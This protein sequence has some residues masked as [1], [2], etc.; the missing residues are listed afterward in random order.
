LTALL[1]GATALLLAPATGSAQ[2]SMGAPYYAGRPSYYGSG[3]APYSPGALSW[4]GAFSYT[5]RYYWY[6]YNWPYPGYYVGRYNGPPYFPAGAAA[7]AGGSPSSS[8]DR[9][10]Y[11]SY[12]AQSGAEESP[13]R[14]TVRLPDADAQV[15]VEGKP[16]R[17]RGSRREFVSPPLDPGQNYTYE[18]RAVWT[19]SGREVE[20]TRTVRVRAGGT[21]TVDFTAADGGTR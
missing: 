14:V 16:T 21:T 8:S 4:P 10:S 2:V 15:W 3:Y 1:L 13:A 17:Q 11:Y 20:R 12:G 6:G 5:Q 18:V 7:P 9:D 19:E